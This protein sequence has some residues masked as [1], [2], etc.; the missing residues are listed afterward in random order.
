MYL[1]ISNNLFDIYEIDFST[2]TQLTRLYI[3]GG[4]CS[5]RMEEQPIDESLC[6]LVKLEEL[7]F[8]MTKLMSLPDEIGNLVNLTSLNVDGSC[9]S[10]LPESITR[11][12]GLIELL[13]YGSAFEC[14]PKNFGNLSALTNLGLKGNCHLLTL[15]DSFTSL[16]QLCTLGLPGPNS[17]VKPPG[18]ANFLI[19]LEKSGCVYEESDM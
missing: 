11:L 14:L 15:P 10:E 19:H 18:Y 9:L 3:K 1:D 6:L 2:M 4:E 17:F 8:N 7:S 5:G 13:A 16:T 12:T